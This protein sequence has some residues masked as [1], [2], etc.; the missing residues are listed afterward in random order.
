MNDLMVFNNVEFGE[1]RSIHVDGKIY[2]VG[3]DVASALGYSNPSKAVSTHCKHI[4]KETID[5]S[6]QNGNAHKARKTQEVSLI[7]EGDVYRLI[8]TSKLPSAEKFE[9]WVFDEVLPTIRQSGVYIP[10]K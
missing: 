4:R 5:V 8:V 3:R 1:I 2:F 10:V 6:S 9:S 7:N